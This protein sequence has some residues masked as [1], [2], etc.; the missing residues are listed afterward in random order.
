M[1]L[2]FPQFR[3]EIRRGQVGRW[4]VELTFSVQIT[5]LI[6]DSSVTTFEEGYGSRLD[7]EHVMKHVGRDGIHVPSVV[8]E[9]FCVKL[10]MFVEPESFFGV[11][12]Q[13]HGASERP[14]MIV[15]DSSR[16][17]VVPPHDLVGL[18]DGFSQNHFGFV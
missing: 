13:K 3:E 16:I 2:Q 7:R 1:R 15:G 4:D 5:P 8:F 6:A 10:A 14:R 17:L 12:T 18:L 11:A 9:D